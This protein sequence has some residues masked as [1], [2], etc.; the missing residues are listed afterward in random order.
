MPN[1][2]GLGQNPQRQVV[3]V[4]MHQMLIEEFGL[5]TRFQAV[6]A[7][8]QMSVLMATNVLQPLPKLRRKQQM[9]S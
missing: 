8:E 2:Y 9:L 6:N 7:W 1:A 4:M 5:Q 3:I